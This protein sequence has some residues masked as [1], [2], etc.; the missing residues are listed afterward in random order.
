MRGIAFRDRLFERERQAK[1]PT[2]H[3]NSGSD[4]APATEIHVG[5]HAL[6]QH[7]HALIHGHTDIPPSIVFPS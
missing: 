2:G 5:V 6:L 1:D 7:L 4:A 3:T